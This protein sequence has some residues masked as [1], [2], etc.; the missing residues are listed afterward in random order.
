MESGEVLYLSKADVA[1]AGV[2]MSQIIETLEKM[3]LENCHY[4]KSNPKCMNV[5][6]IVTTGLQSTKANID[7]QP[8]RLGCGTAMS[9]FHDYNNLDIT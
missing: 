1:A 7:R 5:W 3:F 6:A 9:F 4:M 2:S 8:S